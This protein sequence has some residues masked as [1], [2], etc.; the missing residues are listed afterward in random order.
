MLS[1]IQ[2]LFYFQMDAQFMQKEKYIGEISYSRLL[3]LVLIVTCLLL[4]TNAASGFYENGDDSLL[5]NLST[6]QITRSSHLIELDLSHENAIFV[7]E[8]IVFS[9]S[10][11]KFPDKLAI[12]LP[13]TAEIDSFQRVEMM[14]ANSEHINYSRSGDILFFNDSE[15]LQESS[16]PALYEVRYAIKDDATLAS[17]SFLKVLYRS[18]QVSYPISRLAVVATYPEGVHVHLTDGMG[19]AVKADSVETETN[20]VS[21]AWT[22]PDIDVLV[23]NTHDPVEPVS[24]TKSS[25]GFVFLLASGAFILMVFILYSRRKGNADI[26]NLEDNYEALLAVILKLEED[27]KKKLIS[28]KE[29]QSLHKKYRYQAMETKKK[30]DNLKK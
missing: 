29:F 21:F 8:S 28:K 12:I 5:L 1:W 7:Q 2:A 4:S 6:A 14:G 25:G 11:G 20:T 10:E 24:G 15:H 19:N 26:R 18:D 16:M 17:R 23:V 9:I 13:E 22:S 3:A 27:H 30:M